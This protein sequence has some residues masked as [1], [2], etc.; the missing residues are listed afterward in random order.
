MPIGKLGI[1]GVDYG[2]TPELTISQF[3]IPAGAGATYAAA[4]NIATITTNAAHGLTFNPAANIPP[5][6]FVTFG[7]STSALVGQGI[8][9]GNVFRILSIP[10]A[11][12]FTIYC[13]ITSGTVTSM[14]VIPVFFHPFIAPP[15]SIWTGG[16]AQPAGTLY[17]PAQLA[18]GSVNM[19]LGANLV[20]SF[21]PDNKLL[22]LDAASTPAAGTPST[23]PVLRT[24]AAAS[25]S[26]QVDF[27]SP[28][29][30]LQASGTTANS[31]LSVIE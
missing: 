15:F 12:T 29:T 31:F 14:T 24:L 19:V 25:T 26:A 18:Q 2:F 28:Q 10:S 6:Y 9:V 3:V 30:L 7:G 23:A 16:P 17:P 11:T 1:L 5:N 27:S 21:N 20:C 4:N 22:L 8:L 13:T